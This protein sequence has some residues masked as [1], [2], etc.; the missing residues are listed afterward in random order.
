M[1]DLQNSFTETRQLSKTHMLVLIFYKFHSKD[2]RR[3][4]TQTHK[5]LPTLNLGHSTINVESTSKTTS[6]SMNPNLSP[7]FACINFLF[8]PRFER[9]KPRTRRYPALDESNRMKSAY[10]TIH[11]GKNPT[12]QNDFWLKSVFL[13]STG[14]TSSTFPIQSDFSKK[15]TGLHYTKYWTLISPSFFRRGQTPRRTTHDTVLEI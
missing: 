4:C 2:S 3:Q 10:F 9:L 14:F 6:Q 7:T 8:C 11:P 15:P 13:E 1:L 5:S 12:S